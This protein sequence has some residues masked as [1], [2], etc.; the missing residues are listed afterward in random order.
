MLRKRSIQNQINYLSQILDDGYDDDLQTRFP[1]GKLFGNSLLALSIIEFCEKYEATDERYAKIVDRCINRIQS[2][3]AL[4]AFDQ[5]LIPSYG[6]FYNGWSNYVY[7]KYI[8]SQLFD[9]SLMR[10]SV[11]AASQNIEKRLASIQSD[12]I[13]ILDTHYDSNWPA[14]NMIGILSLDDDNLRKRWIT[15]ILQTTQH[16]SGLIHHSGFDAGVIRGSSSAMITFC[17]GKSHFKNIAAY[18][19]KHMDTFIDTYLG[20]QLVKENEDGSGYMDVDS[21][22]ILFGYGASATIMNIKTQASLGNSNSTITWA[23]M[24]LIAF[25]VNIFGRKY[26]LLKKEPMLDLFM[27]WA[28]T[29]L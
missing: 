17:L 29:E 6:M 16:K 7:T 26:Y 19:K 5:N 28:C 4:E 25:P 24:N 14:D 3:K 15:K 2:K 12:S 8:N 9:H 11:I 23:A 22:P 13:F 1:E 21:G 20:I 18:N 27:L 10:D